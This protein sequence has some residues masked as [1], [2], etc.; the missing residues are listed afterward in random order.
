MREQAPRIEIRV[1]SLLLVIGA[2]L[3]IVL[4]LPMWFRLLRGDLQATPVVLLFDFLFVAL[5][6]FSFW[7][8]LKLWSGAPV[9]INWAKILLL[10]QIP[11]IRLPG[12]VYE[13]QTL[14]VATRILFNDGP[15]FNL[16][17]G[18]AI[19]IYVSSTIHDVIVGVNVV[20]IIAL[21]CLLRASS[22]N[23]AR[24]RNSNNLGLI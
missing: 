20:A 13:F 6:A 10:A 2:A 14:G 5:F 19:T 16:H 7:V 8:G 9:A 4:G 21:V 15:H 24:S 22:S 11:S 12:F 3:G 23:T 17:L 18:S 1:I